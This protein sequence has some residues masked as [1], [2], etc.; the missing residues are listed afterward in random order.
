MIAAALGQAEEARH[1]LGAAH[2]GLAYLPP[3]QVPVLETALTKLG[4]PEADR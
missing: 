3:L 2:D 1:L 4:S